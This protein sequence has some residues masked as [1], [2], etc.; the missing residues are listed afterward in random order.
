[1]PEAGGQEKTEKATPKRRQDAREKGNVPKSQELP[2]AAVLMAGLLTLSFT[3]AYM[4]RNLTEMARLALSQAGQISLSQGD[5]SGFILYALKNAALTVAPIMVVVFIV[6]ILANVAQ[7]GFL[8]SQ[9][10]LQPKFDKLNP[11]KGM[12]KFFSLRI[13]VD[14]F[15]SI[16]KLLAVGLVAWLT[17]E[18]EMA[19]LATLAAWPVEEIITYILTICFEIFLKCALVILALAFADWAYQKYEYEKNLKMS[20][21]EVKDEFKQREGDPMVKS[22]IRSIQ[23]Q[24]ANQRMMEAVPDADVVVTNPTHLAVALLYRAEVMNA[25]QIVAKG[26]DRIAE[27]IKAMAAE[28]DIPVVEEKP[29]AQALFKLEIGQFVPEELFQAVAHVLAYVYQLKGQRQA[30]NG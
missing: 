13:I 12:K 25:P 15:K 3:A 14:T 6:A 5:S 10:A 30:A 4:W 1:M 29:L 9:K 20:K 28:N 16:F 2:S 27:R 26:A 19:T 8:F 23:R 7:F 22:R 21:Q 24:L 18:D 17:V 11:I